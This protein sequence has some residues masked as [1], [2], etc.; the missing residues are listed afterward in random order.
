MKWAMIAIGFLSTLATSAIA[1][2]NRLNPI[3]DY[4]LI[5][6]V[7]HTMDEA[8]IAIV[9]DYGVQGL[10]AEEGFQIFID[11]EEVGEMSLRLQ[12]SYY[13]NYALV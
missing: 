9:H 4:A 7:I 11:L 1:Q 8:G 3:T 5:S 13:W 12:G 2:S 6:K 10:G